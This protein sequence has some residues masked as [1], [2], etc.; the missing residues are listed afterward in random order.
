M[1]S[2]YIHFMLL[3]NI[4]H[5]HNKSNNVIFFFTNQEIF[6]GWREKNINGFSIP[7]ASF[8]FEDLDGLMNMKSLINQPNNLKVLSRI[9]GS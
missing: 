4:K 8:L 2:R 9:T 7:K 6:Q 5:F 1:P 3:L